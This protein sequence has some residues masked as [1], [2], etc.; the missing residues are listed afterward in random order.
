MIFKLLNALEVRI[1]ERRQV[2]LVTFL[3][4]LQNPQNSSTKKC[5]VFPL[6]WKLDI[7]KLSGKIL[8]RIYPNSC[9]ETDSDDEY[10][11]VSYIF[12]IVLCFLKPYFLKKKTKW[13]KKFIIYIL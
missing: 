6:A 5:N 1:Q 9:M 4:Y 3:I 2:E 8:S 11:G 13:N 10:I 7:V 12:I